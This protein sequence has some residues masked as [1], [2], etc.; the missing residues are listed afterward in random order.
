MIKGEDGKKYIDVNYE[1]VKESNELE[2]IEGIYFNAVQVSKMLGESDSTIRYWAKEFGDILNIKM[3]NGIKKYTKT[4]IDN[5]KYIRKLLKEDNF[6]ISQAYEYCCKKGFNSETG[7]I[8]ANNHLAVKS[9]ITA[10]TMEMDDKIKSM[11]TNVIESNKEFMLKMMEFQKTINEE[12]Q[13]SIA[14]TVDE[15]VSDKLDSFKEEF[16]QRIQQELAITKEDSK[17][18]TKMREMLEQRKLESE[19]EKK[20]GFFSRLFK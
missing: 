13:K 10:M 6:T 2:N 18:I 1:S 14:I 15:V 16:V 9:L 19:T 4:D 12:I 8:D 11:Q 5:L 3:I 7:L 17:N 20:V